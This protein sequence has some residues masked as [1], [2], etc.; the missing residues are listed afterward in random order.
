MPIR[1]NTFIF[2]HKGPDRNSDIS[3]VEVFEVIYINR[4]GAIFS[5]LPIL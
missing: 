2:Q 5:H 1:A 3:L 4:K